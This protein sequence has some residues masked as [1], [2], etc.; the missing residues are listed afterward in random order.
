M[1]VT[2]VPR[3]VRAGLFVGA[4]LFP[5]TPIPFRVDHTVHQLSDATSTAPM[6]LGF[7]AGSHPMADAM[8]Y[9]PNAPVGVHPPH[10]QH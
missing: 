2:R 8:G 4:V 1:P 7:G 9:E 6:G 3:R 10:I 5:F